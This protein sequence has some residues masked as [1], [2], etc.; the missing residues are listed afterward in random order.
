MKRP[1]YV[2]PLSKMVDRMKRIIII[3]RLII[4]IIDPI[5]V[6]QFFAAGGSFISV[7]F[8]SGWVKVE[9]ISVFLLTE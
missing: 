5:I 2:F 9:N 6:S 8:V 1:R 3:R 7:R 4:A